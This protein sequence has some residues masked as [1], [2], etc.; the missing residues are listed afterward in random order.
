MSCSNKDLY[1]YDLVKKRCRYKIFLLISNFHKKLG[2]KDGL[3]PRCIPCLEKY[4]S[5]NRDRVK[6][7]FL[8]NQG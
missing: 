5:D 3:D 4:Y 7:Y 8:N 1:V 2:S 6:Q